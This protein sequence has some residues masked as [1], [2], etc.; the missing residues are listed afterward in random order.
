[1]KY[2]ISII[3]IYLSL[4][5]SLYAQKHDYNWI[6]GYGDFTD[7]IPERNGMLLDFNGAEVEAGIFEK[8]QFFFLTNLAY[9]DADGALQLY[10]DGCAFYDEF[11]DL[12]MNGDDINYDSFCQ[13]ENRSGYPENQGMIALPTSDKSI[14]AVFYSEQYLVSDT[15]GNR[16]EVRL[17]RA[18]ID[19]SDNVVLS[20]KEIYLNSLASSIL[21]ATK[22]SNG[23]DWWII[24]Q[25]Y[26]TNEIKCLLVSE[27]EIIDTVSTFI[28]LPILAPGASQ[29]NFSPDG[30][31][32]ARFSPIS[33]LQ[34]YD[35]DRST[36]ALSNHK[37]IEIPNV[38]EGT[39]SSGGLA[40]SGSSRF[41]YVND[42]LGIW[43]LDLEAEDIE[44]SI[45]QVA[46]REEFYT[47]QDIFGDEIPTFFYKSSLAPD[48]RIY[49]CSRGGTDR[50]YVIMEPEQ[51]GIAC[52]VVQNIKMPAWNAFSIAQYPN[53]RLDNSP[54]CDASKSF[55]ESLDID[56]STSSQP[57]LDKSDIY[58]Y[59]NPAINS[60]NLYTKHLQGDVTL[61]L[62][63]LLGQK[64]HSTNLTSSDDTNNQRIDIRDVPSGLYIYSVYDEDHS[65]LYS[66]RLVVEK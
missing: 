57:L 35:F 41:I 65:L 51:K 17:N 21:S 56:V 25:D 29:S 27:G 24:N 53:Y 32:F 61:E 54:A 62:H 42:A 13:G 40:F 34:L 55:P 2:N 28:G 46:E 37:I 3:F 4:S 6:N 11:G 31:M 64:I 38:N 14:V 19:L 5:T 50:M 10:S 12:L 36:G 44:G 9:S 8:D 33:E 52:D 18:M 49:I 26:F 20:K 48:C 23:Q 66:D 45:V 7:N 30:T 43:Q 1:M 22:H 58:V 59:P 63:D 47:G 16:F 60:V 39:L 15:L